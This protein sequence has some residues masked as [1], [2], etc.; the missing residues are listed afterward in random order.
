[1]TAERTLGMPMIALRSDLQPCARSAA[2]TGGGTPVVATY[3]LSPG[4]GRPELPLADC[5]FAAARAGW[6]VSREFYDLT[7]GETMLA[8]RPQWA[9]AQS[10]V[11]RRQID[12]IVV[13]D[14]THVAVDGPAYTALEEWALTNRI[15]VHFL[16]DSG[17]IFADGH[18]IGR[19]P[20]TGEVA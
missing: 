3:G 7:G 15:F 8:L 16:R 1:M 14:R 19:R 17:G 18:L 20:D 9:A 5:R 11:G 2:D 6:A 10:L 13:A 4:L 12:G